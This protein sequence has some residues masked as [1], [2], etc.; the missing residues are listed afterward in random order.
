MKIPIAVPEGTRVMLESRFTKFS[1]LCV[2]PRVGISRS[3]AELETYLF[4]VVF[5]QCQSEFFI[6]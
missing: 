4:L 5:I 3:S 6:K 1:T 2:D